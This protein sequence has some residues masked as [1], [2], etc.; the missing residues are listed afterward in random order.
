MSRTDLNLF[1]H[2][3]NIPIIDLHDLSPVEAVEKLHRELYTL[4]VHKSEFCRV[5]HGV[6][7]GVL[8]KI[9]S[10]ELSKNPLIEVFF[11]DS[12]GGSTTVRLYPH[13]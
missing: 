10:E 4:G 11:I 8:E 13:Y 12:H 7:Q 5:V 1:E 2:L 6:G 9:V 3:I